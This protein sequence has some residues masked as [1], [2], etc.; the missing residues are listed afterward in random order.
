MLF[1]PATVGSSFHRQ[2]AKDAE[3]ITIAIGEA[4]DPAAADLAD[5]LTLRFA[6][7]DHGD[8][9]EDTLRAEVRQFIDARSAP[10]GASLG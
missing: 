5:E 2:D 3:S 1:S 8:W 4:A 7:Y 6:E 10:H 9:D